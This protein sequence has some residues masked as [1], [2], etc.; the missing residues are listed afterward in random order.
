M[1]VKL[2]LSHSGKNIEGGCLKT[3]VRGTFGLETGSGGTLEKNL[4][5][6]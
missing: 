3:V 6:R 4:V 2:G 5:P 1:G